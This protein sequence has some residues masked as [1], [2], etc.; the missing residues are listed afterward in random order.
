MK[1]T[2]I[3]AYIKDHPDAVLEDI[4]EMFGRSA[5]LIYK[6]AKDIGITLKTRKQVAGHDWLNA[7]DVKKADAELKELMKNPKVR[8][9]LKDNWFEIK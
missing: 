1:P 2:A 6:Y 5:G 4:A 7:E 8:K 3:K 9:W